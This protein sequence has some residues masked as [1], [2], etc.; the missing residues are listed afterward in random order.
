[1]VNDLRERLDAAAGE[2][3]HALDVERLE[4]RTARLRVRRRVRRLT[5]AVIVIVVGFVGVLRYSANGS[6]DRTSRVATPATPTPSPLQVFDAAGDQVALPSGWFRA[7]VPL[8]PSL[9]WP[10]EI[11]AVA[12]IPLA[13]DDRG[14]GCDT[15]LPRGTLER[16][17]PTDAF[18]WLVESTP[19]SNPRGVTYPDPSDLPPRPTHFD[20]GRFRALE[21][22]GPTWRFPDLRFRQFYF[23][24]NSRGFGAYVVLGDKVTTK[25]K[26]QVRSV[27]DSLDLASPTTG[28]TIRVEPVSGGTD[29]VSR[30]VI[31]AYNADGLPPLESVITSQDAITAKASANATQIR[32]RYP[33]VID[34]SIGPGY[35]RAWTR[36]QQG[37]EVVPV[38][39]YAIIV[40]VEQPSQCPPT[41]TAIDGAS[42]FFRHL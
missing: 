6:G 40:T 27:L 34:I 39:D 30:D 21:C 20:L 23:Q 32:S 16:M 13:P 18:V 2:P 12:A 35:Q 19:P 28:E 17:T 4:R 15:Q 25:R 33:G 42:I 9:L 37:I 31:N 38:N 29:C 3:E 10:K 14:P 7:A 41:P 1:V 5:T 24:Q 8:T 11:L 22:S 26:A 36:T